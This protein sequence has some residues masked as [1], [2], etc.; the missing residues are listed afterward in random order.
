MWKA[1]TIVLLVLAMSTA[2]DAIFIV[3]FEAA[4]G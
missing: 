3:L 2:V 1:P 4:Y